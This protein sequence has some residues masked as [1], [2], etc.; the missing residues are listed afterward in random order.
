MI[1]G[2]AAPVRQQ[3]GANEI[4]LCVEISFQPQD[5]GY[6]LHIDLRAVEVGQLFPQCSVGLVDQAVHAFRQWLK[7][8]VFD[9]RRRIRPSS[10]GEKG[11]EDVVIPGV[12]SASSSSAK[13]GCGSFYQIKTDV[14][15]KIHRHGKKKFTGMSR[16]HIPQAGDDLFNFNPFQQVLRKLCG[17][18][19]IVPPR[20]A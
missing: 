7:K 2:K 18:R 8:G 19:H 11:G 4:R 10:F 9:F 1:F 16:A 15:G 12:D 6:V 13:E 14:A 17:H 5:T 20:E 3:I